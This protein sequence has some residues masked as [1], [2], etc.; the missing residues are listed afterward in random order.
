MNI[1]A[2]LVAVLVLLLVW[3]GM[4]ILPWLPLTVLLKVPLQWVCLSLYLPFLVFICR[5]S[6]ETYSCPA[7]AYMRLCWDW[8][9]V[10]RFTN[11]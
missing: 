1:G 2:R 11:E 9:Q 5:K 4:I 3:G 8:P 10:N 6:S 7:R